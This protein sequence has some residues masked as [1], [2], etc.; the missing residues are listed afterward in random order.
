MTR[1]RDERPF[2]P[3]E[4]I[5]LM[6]NEDFGKATG[7]LQSVVLSSGCYT[8]WEVIQLMAE[9]IARRGLGDQVREALR[10]GKTVRQL[11]FES[12]GIHPPT[13]RAS[14]CTPPYLE[15]RG[16]RRRI[17]Y[18]ETDIRRAERLRAGPKR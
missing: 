12:Y 10:S 11:M 4:F 9:D 13:P 14:Y 15:A 18:A 16:L 5:E 1:T 6:P 7:I 3:A 2:A 17:G 8:F